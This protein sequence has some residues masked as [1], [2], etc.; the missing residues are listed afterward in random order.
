MMRK[1]KKIAGNVIVILVK[2]KGVIEIRRG[3]KTGVAEIMVEIRTENAVI[4]MM[5]TIVQE[6]KI[7]VRH[8]HMTIL[9]EREMGMITKSHQGQKIVIL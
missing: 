4:Q 8:R 1:K 5:K 2:V 6:V 3:L 7:E 9:I